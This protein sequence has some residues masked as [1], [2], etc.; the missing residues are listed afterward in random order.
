[1]SMTWLLVPD[2][3][4]WASE[5]ADLLWFSHISVTR[6][7]REWCEKQKT[8]SWSSDGGQKRFVNKRGQRRARL[9]EVDRKVTVMQITTHYNSGMQKSISEHT[10]HKTSKWTG[11][12]SRRPVRWKN[13]SN[14]YLIKFSELDIELNEAVKMFLFLWPDTIK[15]GL[16][17]P[18]ERPFEVARHMREPFGGNVVS[19]IKYLLWL[20]LTGLVQ[21]KSRQIKSLSHPFLND[22]ACVT[23]RT[24]L[25]TTDVRPGAVPWKRRIL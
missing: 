12:C 5:T 20:W 7:C 3:V 18:D 8:S 15:N 10:T 4:V 24:K 14:K 1:M 2:R 16:K 21:I 22:P 23:E 19:E 13:R 9:I 11:N 6:V 17:W 25:H